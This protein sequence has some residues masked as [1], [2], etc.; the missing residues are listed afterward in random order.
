MKRTVVA[1]LVALMW[2][3]AASAAEWSVTGATLLSADE[4]RAVVSGVESPEDAGKR[5]VEAY[6][7]RGYLTVEVRVNAVSGAI[8]V[9]EGVARPTGSY[10]G[11]LPA[12]SVLTQDSIELASARMAAAARL[13]GERV[14]VSVRPA[15]PDGSVEV[16]A[17]AVAVPGAKMS[18]GNLIFSTLGQ[19]YSGNDVLTGYIWKNAGDAQQLDASI[20]HAFSDWREDSRK[21]RFDNM[22]L[23]W[24]KAHQYGLTSLQAMHAEYRTGGQAAPLDVNGQIDRVNIE[25]GYL[26]TPRLT[27]TARLSYVNNEQRIGAFGWRDREE[28]GSLT[29]GARYAGAG[30]GYSYSMEGGVEQGL[31]GRRNFN[32]VPLMGEFD[33]DFTAF[34]FHVQGS[35]ALGDDYFLTGKIGAQEGSKGTPSAS[36]FYLGGPDRGRSYNTGYAAMPSGHYASVVLTVPSLNGV[37]PYLGYDYGRGKP[38]VGPDRT[39]QSGFI[40]ASYRPTEGMS[41]DLS[42]AQAIDRLDDPTADRARWNLTASI[43]F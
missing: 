16:V 34:S 1:A 32:F 14:A 20:A 9:V 22:T 13:N 39:A 23:G 19:R 5:V 28:Y 11:Y 3:G 37:V 15:R 36:Q 40:G 42:Y 24:R 27:G 25:H 18:G 17:E 41:L 35:R 7:A 10:S 8:T 31:G 12:G 4:L 29:L 2:A 26:F 21:G 43:A 33:A 6:R 30:A 38:V